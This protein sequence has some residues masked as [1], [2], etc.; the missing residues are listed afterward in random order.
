[1]CTKKIN[2]SFSKIYFDAKLLFE[3]CKL[4]F[5]LV[6][7]YFAY[8]VVN[9]ADRW[10]VLKMLGDHQLGV[11]AIAARMSSILEP[12]LLTPILGAYL[13]ISFKN[14]AKGNY[15][16]KI[17]LISIVI[18]IVFIVFAFVA[19][20]LLPYVL[21]SKTPKEMY[22]LMPYFIVG[23]SFYFIAQISVNLLVYKK[24]FILLLKNISI[25]ALTNIGL[26]VFLLKYIG[27]IGA[28]YAFLISNAV[29]MFLSLYER[30]RIINK[31]L[32]E[33]SNDNC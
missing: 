32:L 17:S 20:P 4:G 16:E 12:L 22:K 28:A 13:P 5:I 6:V 33:D 7:G 29:W 3:K 11:Y 23:Y 21:S 18:I 24:Y 8:W 10:I 9:G 14:Y 31:I 1:L 15:N 26:N 2:I 30:R 19:M 25:V 27:L